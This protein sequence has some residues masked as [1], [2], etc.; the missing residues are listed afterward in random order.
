MYPPSSST[1]KQLS[2]VD[3]LTQHKQINNNKNWKKK[4]SE[5][6]TRNKTKE[7]HLGEKGKHEL[8]PSST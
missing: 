8:G 7:T 5:L 3:S 6:G 4:T 1:S 2:T